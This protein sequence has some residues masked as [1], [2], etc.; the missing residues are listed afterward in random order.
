MNLWPALLQWVKH[1]ISLK[2]QTKQ[3]KFALSIKIKQGGL[4]K[5]KYD[6][7]SETFEISFCF[8]FDHHKGAQ[9]AEILVEVAFTYFLES[10]S[11]CYNYRQFPFDSAMPMASHKLFLSS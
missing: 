6:S 7:T 3:S 2:K 11:F 8:Y 10:V 4:G 9:W 1:L 5:K